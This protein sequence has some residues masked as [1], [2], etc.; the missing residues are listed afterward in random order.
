MKIVIAVLSIILL[1]QAFA[2]TDKPLPAETCQHD[3]TGN[4]CKQAVLD[5]SQ[6][7]IR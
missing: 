6:I 3:A 7:E 1:G 4:F 2:G 5:L